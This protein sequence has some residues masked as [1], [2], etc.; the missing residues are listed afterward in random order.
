MKEDVTVLCT[1]GLTV[2]IFNKSE[3]RALLSK[4]RTIRGASREFTVLYENS[5]LVR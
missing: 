2:K 3:N 5:N 1:D 4:K